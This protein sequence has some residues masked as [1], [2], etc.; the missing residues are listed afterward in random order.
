MNPLTIE[1]WIARFF[2]ELEIRNYSPYTIKGMRC[3]LGYFQRFL[4]ERNIKTIEAVTSAT[5]SEFQQWYF[6]QPTFR[7]TPRSVHDQNNTLKAVKG[8]FGFLHREGLFQKDLA[9]S[10]EYAKEPKRLPR[11]VLTEKEANKILDSIDISTPLGYRSRCL[12]EVLYATGIRKNEARNLKVQDVNLE[13][14]LL[15]IKEGKGSVDRVCPLTQISCHFLNIYIKAI[16]PQLL[17]GR[18][19]DYLFLSVRGKQLDP[20]TFGNLVKRHA[21]LAKIQKNVTP[22]V[23]RHTMATA[24]VRNNAPLKAVQSVLGHKNVSSSERYLHL[25]MNDIRQAHKKFHPRE[26]K[27]ES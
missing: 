20:Q 21:K 14:G 16:R 19:P 25:S 6:Y 2:T 8:L 3:N 23:W 11:N 26:R 1:Q 5:L 9:A 27:T 22:H 18:N 10:L 24:L 7:G 12:L 17:C 13:D 4:T 15:F